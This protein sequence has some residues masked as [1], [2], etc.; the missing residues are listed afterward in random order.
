MVNLVSMVKFGFWY[1]L[2]G[3]GHEM[4]HVLCAVFLR[5]WPSFSVQNLVALMLCRRVHIPMQTSKTS[6]WCEAAVRNAGWVGSVLLMLISS[7]AGLSLTAQAA[8]AVTLFEAV[9]SDLCA[10]WPHPGGDWFLCGNFGLVLLN[11]A[12]A[13]SSKVKDILESMVEVT[14]LR[15][16]QT[17]GVVTF[18][19]G[20]GHTG[21]MTSMTSMTGLRTRVVNKKRTT[22]SEL[23][24]QGLE[25]TERWS[26]RR[27][28]EFGRIYAGHTRFATSSK[29]TFDGTHPHQWSSP[30]SL[31]MYIGWSEGC[32]KGKV[33]KNFEIFVTH[34]G[35]F[36]FLDVGDRTYELGAIQDWLER[37]TGQ[38]RPSGVDSAAIAGVMDLMRTQGSVFL[39][40]RFGFLFGVKR[41]TLDYE[42]PPQKTFQLLGTLMDEVLQEYL[43]DGAP[44]GASTSLSSLSSLEARQADL[45]QNYFTR[46]KTKGPN[47]SLSDDD[48]L[49]MAETAISAFLENDLLLA[50]RLFMTKAKGSFGLC[51]MCS[52][53]AHRQMVIAARGQTMSVAF[54]PETGLL[55]YASEQAAVKA[56]LGIKPDKHKMHESSDI[57]EKSRSTSV[58]FSRNCRSH[59]DLEEF[60]DLEASLSM[61]SIVDDG[62]AMRLDLDDLGGEVCLLDW[63]TG[64]PFTSKS[65]RPFT[66]QPMMNSTLTVTSVPETPL[67][68]AQLIPIED[69]EMVFPLPKTIPDPVGSDIKETP[70]VL[71][72]IQMD[73]R[74][75]EGQ[76]RAAAWSL[77][78]ALSNRL[79]QKVEGKLAKDSVDLLITGCEVSL[80]LGEQM[81]ADFNL[82]FKHLVVKT[83]SSN[84]LLGLDG[85]EIPMAQT[86]HCISEN[87]WD[88]HD[89]V[90]LIISHSGATFAPLAV[91]KLL[92]SVTNRI[93][94]V[95]S[96]LDT[97]IGKQLR[98][99][100]QL[101]H[102]FSTNLSMRPAE[103][104][105]ISVAAT[106]QLLTQILMYVA[107]RLVSGQLSEAAGAV[108]TQTD[109]N[110]LER[111]NRE[112]IHALKEI[113]GYHGRTETEHELRRR[114]RAWAQHVLETPRAWIL[115]AVYIAFTVTLASPPFLLVA[116]TLL[117]LGDFEYRQE[118]L[119]V[120]RAFDAAV[121][122]FLPQLM[123]LLIRLLQCRPLL[124]RM[125]AR[126]VVIGDIPW[127]AQSVEAFLSKLVAC[128][129][130]AT[131]L[132]VFSANP[133]DHLVHRMTHR[134][135]RGTLLACGRPDGRL[136]A[137]TSGEQSV[138]LAVNQAS[139][140]QSMGETCESLTI[141]HNPYKLPLT[142][143]HVCLKDNRPKYLCEHLLEQ[144]EGRTGEKEEKG[145]KGENAK[146][147]AALIGCF[148]QLSDKESQHSQ[149]L[150][151]RMMEQKK[152]EEEKRQAR[153]EIDRVVPTLQTNEDGNVVFTDFEK[154][155]ASVGPKD[156]T[157]TRKEL[158]AV[159]DRF[160]GDCDGALTQRECRLIYAA[161]SVTLLSYAKA[162][163]T[164]ST[165]SFE[166]CWSI[167]QSVEDFFG[168]HVLSHS[169]SP[170]QAF[171]LAKTQ[172]VSMLLYEGRIASLQ[173]AVAFFV[174]F[175][176]MGKCISDFWPS[177]SFGL[178]RYRM[179]RTHSIMRVATTASPVSGSD[180]REKMVV[181]QLKKHF[182]RFEALVQPY[183]RTWR[184]RHNKLT[185]HAV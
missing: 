167:P 87:A 65:L 50:T 161:D 121:Y 172:N 96:E 97:Q 133:A 9:L 52:V 166:K 18:A 55:L 173:R 93:F 103:P 105:S 185:Q 57:A 40:A 42:M 160:D 130:S 16:A 127:V 13:T 124:H 139:S 71:E 29:A 67:C 149:H 53:D 32:L 158:K 148:A 10:V 70:Q 63:G 34:N 84:K 22:L 76:N 144:E 135:V 15:G 147:A 72:K 75:A 77:S 62:S 49:A 137:L 111:L 92:Q 113:V 163:L 89:S 159:F 176:E 78:R 168:S 125:T 102:V 145:E 165:E 7:S 143:H 64:V 151:D 108:V 131:S 155:F 41:L 11:S 104:C 118:W 100:G 112:N 141:G 178:L 114:G 82:C 128:T 126:T 28:P 58:K 179:D 180:V 98:D 3:V 153:L 8:A 116:R 25:S 162:K 106:Q 164:G 169:S 134:V 156:L 171:K 35:D 90:V 24:R 175:H 56:A 123:M 68:P 94:V 47:L 61:S 81:A 184:Q 30:Q 110:E 39:S 154:G 73:W 182:A 17:G 95:T 170:D 138:C 36:D 183:V 46:I 44:G 152:A 79:R 132:T 122:I 23:L 74:T 38:K 14:M 59:Q 101:S 51:V 107:S 19:P 31:D 117:S 86:G 1:W 48:L 60:M 142:A 2:F 6:K 174:M 83:I 157:L 54:Y 99:L 5:H 115:C 21:D 150:W 136:M 177:V 12:W 69:N 20:R 109:L 88:L 33:S 120:A 43:K 91:S 181:L 80:W 26:F 129:Y 119:M 27:L 66:P 45:V 140:I 37:A 4:S 85:L 146:S